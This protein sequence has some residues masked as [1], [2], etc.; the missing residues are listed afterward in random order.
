MSLPDQPEIAKHM[1]VQHE[2]L[3]ANATPK[4]R[5]GIEYCSQC[6]F[7]LRASWLAQELLFTFGTQLGEVALRPGEGGGVSR[8][9]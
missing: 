4:P 2:S 3:T 7:V 5:V 9:A 8:V 1:A 6:R